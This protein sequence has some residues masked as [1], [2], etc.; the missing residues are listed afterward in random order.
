MDPKKKKSV[1]LP[2][3]IIPLRYEIT[4]KPDL[5]AFT[6]WGEETIYLTSKT[7]HKEITLHAVELDIESAQIFAKHDDAFAVRIS[8]DEKAETATFV[9]PRRLPNGELRL[10]LLFRGVLNDKMRGFYRSRY[11]VKGKTKNMATTQFES[12]DARRA[13]PCFDEPAIKAEFDVSL[14]VPEDATAISNTIPSEVAKHGT[15][16]KIIKFERTPKMST[17]LLAFIVGDFE[18]LEKKTKEGTLVRVFTTPGKKHQAAFALDCAIKTL[19]FF[20]DYFDIPYPLPVLDLIAIPDFSAGAMENWGAVTYRE[21]AL[22]VDT[23]HSSAAT[24]QRVAI[25]IAHELAHQ[26]FGN[27]VTMEWWTHLWLNEGF[28]SYIEYL[29]TDHLFPE[30]DI[31]TQFAYGD[32]GTAMELDA[33]LTTHPIEVEVHHPSEIAEIFDAVSYSKGASIIR[34]LA[35]YLGEKDFRDGLRYYLKKHS[36]QNTATTHLWAAFEKI[37]GKPVSRMMHDWTGRPGYPLV[38]VSNGTDGFV[39]EQKRF[40]SSAIS[41]KKGDMGEPWFIPISLRSKN[42]KKQQFVLKRRTAHLLAKGDSWFKVNVGE[43]GFFRTKYPKDIQKL[44]GAPV[45]AKELPPIDR[46]GL[47]R[48]TMA[49]SE[50]GDTSSVE[51]LAFARNYREEEDYTVWAELSAGLN[52]LRSLIAGEP[53]EEQYRRFVGALFGPIVQK[54]GWQKRKHEAHTQI[55]TRSLI[56]AMAG[57]YGDEAVIARAKKMFAGVSPIR[58]LIDPD[59]RGPVYNVTAKWGGIKEYEKLIKLYTSA[60]LHEEKNR[61]GRA[62]TAFTRKEVLKKAL[63]FSISDAVRKQ[64]ATSIIAGIWY[65]PVGSDLAWDFV[66]K[67]WKSLLERYGVGHDLPRLLSAIEAFRSLE[68]AKEIRQFFKDHPTPAAARTIEQGIESIYSNVAWLAR[69]R[70]SIANFLQDF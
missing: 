20:N 63:A 12:T 61:L 55:L 45:R 1:R 46:L 64:D 70:K 48:D 25:V 24:K 15:G 9:F 54:V 56:L 7:A 67:N 62:L 37:S 30:W 11:E 44:L 17:Y 22:L 38:N 28:A 52:K 35:D 36:Y 49:L 47:I 59:L 53:F 66:K 50:A 3:H 13:F 2:G 31:W 5:N 41:K 68:K 21:A 4:L 16:Y 43:T 57:S 27:L 42:K 23:D 60:S 69:D 26:W 32:L 65:N 10:K 51:A 6:F 33:L 58:N 39:M 18:H 19:S 40:F 29:A 14:I 8:Y 34:M